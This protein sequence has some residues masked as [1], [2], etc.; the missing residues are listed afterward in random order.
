MPAF[1][2]R[3][4]KIRGCRH[5][6]LIA[7]NVVFH[8]LAGLR[9]PKPLRVLCVSDFGKLDTSPIRSLRYFNFENAHFKVFKT[10]ALLSMSGTARASRACAMALRAT[11]RVCLRRLAL[12]SSSIRRH[13]R[14]R[15]T[16]AGA[17][18]RSHHEQFQSEIALRILARRGRPAPPDTL[19]ARGRFFHFP[20]PCPS[21][22][23]PV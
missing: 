5:E 4:K 8:W 19:S 21:A 9:R 1:P 12:L 17:R 10:L 20:P 7:K 15:L 11:L 23:P 14:Q 2:R 13:S 22:S 6:R 18:L 16:P 3:M